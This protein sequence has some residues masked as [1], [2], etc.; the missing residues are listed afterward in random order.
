M[1]HDCVKNWIEYHA[2]CSMTARC[3]NL[4]LQKQHKAMELILAPLISELEFIAL[5]KFLV[6][7]LVEDAF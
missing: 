4:L 5:E 2:C 1:Q 7:A 6:L 3:D